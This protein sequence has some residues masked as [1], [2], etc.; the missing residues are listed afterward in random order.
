MR[1]DLLCYA[2]G[3]LDE[4]ARRAIEVELAKSPEL[5]Q[6]LDELRRCLADLD[7]DQDDTPPMPRGLAQRTASQVLDQCAERRG[8][9]SNKPCGVGSY[10]GKAPLSL[11]DSMVA[12]GV[13]LAMASLLVPALSSSRSMSRRMACQNNLKSLHSYLVLFAEDHRDYYPAIGPEDNAGSFAM[14][15]T[16]SGLVSRDEL[17]E[18]LTCA[19]RRGSSCRDSRMLPVYVPTHEEL[20]RASAAVQ[21]RLRAQ[22]G[23]DMGYRIGYE[24]NGKY[25]PVE[26]QK[27]CRLA[28]LG[29][30]PQPTPDGYRS[31]NHDGGQNVLWQDGTVTFEDSCLVPGINDHLYLN[32]AGLPSAGIG[33]CD[34]VLSPSHATPGVAEKTR[35]AKI[36][37]RL[38][39]IVPQAQG[40]KASAASD[41]APGE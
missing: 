13:M 19:G 38:R 35:P 27:H 34:A 31:L 3:E 36:F 24:R 11:V 32:K 12:I 14:Q 40:A 28:V 20:Q 8:D 4:E 7:A 10:V 39:V 15:L 29:D 2:L 17:Q 18:L 37:I 41:T 26:N 21:A 6:E 9:S 30:A 23:G 33:W 5:Q 1:E 22:M 16:G 25:F